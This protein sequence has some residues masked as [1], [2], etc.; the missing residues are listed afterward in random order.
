MNIKNNKVKYTRE[1]IL[2]ATRES[3]HR[4]GVE[5]EDIGSIVLELQKEYSN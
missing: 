1:D 2:K 3:L 4:R 5:I